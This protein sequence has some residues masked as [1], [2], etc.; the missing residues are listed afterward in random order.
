MKATRLIRRV[1]VILAFLM[2]VCLAKADGI[3]HVLDRGET[4]DYVANLYGTTVEAIKKANPEFVDFYVGM[5]IS[6]PVNKPNGDI[7]RQR[8]FMQNSLYAEAEQLM[9]NGKYKDAVKRY[10][11][12]SVDGETPIN[13]HYNRGL[14]Q[15]K[16]GKY[17]DSIR[18]LSYVVKNDTD[19]SFPDAER[20]LDKVQ[21]EKRIKDEER[22]QMWAGIGQALAQTAVVASQVYSMHEANKAQRK[23]A[24]ASAASG[25]GIGFGGDNSDGEASEPDE[26]G[27]KSKKKGKCSYCGG[28]G[29]FVEYTANYGIDTKPWCDECGKTVV[30]GHY[31][32]KCSFCDG[33]GMR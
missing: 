28:R 10:D 21:N 32:K 18:D 20:I 17:D 15:W 8:L 7:E 5:E 12:I 26:P 33:T 2:N 16:R 19:D 1:A 31:H 11:L 22:R 13:V 4:I 27:E 14:A 24:K 30:S 23:A 25:S 29:S 9:Q 6:I 3:V